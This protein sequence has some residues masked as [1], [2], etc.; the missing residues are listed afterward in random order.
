[1]RT[2]LSWL[3]GVSVV[4]VAATLPSSRMI[5]VAVK[6]AAALMEPPAAARDE[7]RPAVQAAALAAVQEGSAATA[8]SPSAAPVETPARRMAR[9]SPFAGRRSVATA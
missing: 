8:A 4:L 9:R 5:W 7:A 2:L 3:G 1:M 6:P